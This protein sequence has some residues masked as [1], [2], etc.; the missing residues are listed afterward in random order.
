MQ[1][2]FLSVFVF[3]SVIYALFLLHPIDLTLEDL[4]RHLINGKVVWQHP[5]VLY[6][7]FYSYT[8]PTH[9]FV[10]HHWLSGAVFYFLVSHGS[11]EVLTASYFLMMLVGLYFFLR[12][13]VDRGGMRWA[14]MV[15]PLGL[16]FLAERHIVRPEG[17]GYVFLLCF[18][19][20][21]D[22]A[23][24]AGRLSWK[25]CALLVGLELLWVNLHISF[26]FGVF[27]VGTYMLEAAV[28]WWRKRD[29]IAYLRS[30]CL[31]LCA[32]SVA[33]LVNPNGLR[34][35]LYPLSIFSQYGYAVVEN[36][37]V[38]FLVSRITDPGIQLYF[39]TASVLILI[40]LVRLLMRRQLNL[41]E[42]TRV[43]IALVLGWTALRNLPLFGIFVFPFVVESCA[44]FAHSMKLSTSARASFNILSLCFGVVL[45]LLFF[46][47]IASGTYYASIS[48]H[49]LGLGYIQNQFAAANFYKSLHITGNIFNNYDIGSY[50]IYTLYPQR[51][52][53]DNR[54]EA[55]TVDF[56]Q[57]EYIP[58]QE[59]DAAWQAE[60]K[61]YD[62]Q[63]IFF[64]Y[65]DL[66]NWAQDFLMARLK[67]SS[68]TVVYMDNIA[69]IFVR[70][71]PENAAIVKAYGKSSQDILQHDYVPVAN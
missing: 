41:G 2:T 67:D 3:L 30:L 51:V 57:K 12:R 10:N 33:T 45:Y 53:V 18:L 61:K 39:V 8:Q 15:A 48:V 13:M 60:M 40:L 36:Q 38:V 64:G 6:T 24:R 37:S 63:A 5:A 52:F 58:M 23:E 54:P 56:F 68:W 20:L 35:A 22:C 28:R 29:R 62:F 26:I 43:V 66:T 46:W 32:V 71:T 4:G 1:K 19:F 9:P 34:G 59:N 49:D 7:N 70:N 25:L 11:I 55:Y 42:L 21:L 16:L 17:F 44:V 69:I 27:V 50:L 31:L 14:A 65:R 47:F